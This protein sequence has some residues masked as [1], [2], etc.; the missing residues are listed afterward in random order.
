MLSFL[1]GLF[2][3]CSGTLMYEVVLTRLLSVISWY[4][5]A[6]V[7]ISMAMFGMTLGALFVQFRPEQFT[8]ALVPR[9]L[10]QASS[11]MAISIPLVLLTVLAFPVG[12]SP[13]IETLYSFVL[14]LAIV[15]VPFFFSG[16]VVCLSLTRA[17]FAIGIVYFADL[18]GASVGCFGS[19]V[20]LKLFDAPSAMFA[21][22]AILFVGTALYYRYA[23]ELRHRTRPMSAALLMLILAVL[24]TSTLHGIQPIWSKGKIDSRD[25]VLAEVWNPISRVRVSKPSDYPSSPWMWGASPHAP[26]VT[27]E[28]L[29]LDIDND[30]GTPMMHFRDDFND[31]DFLRYDVTS[32]A[33][34]LRVGGTAAIL[35][36]GGGRDAI[37]ALT[38]H[39]HRVVGI[40]VNCA[41][42]DITTRRFDWFSGFSKMPRLEVHCDEGRSY[43]SRSQERFDVVQ[44]SLVDTWAATSAG[45]MTLSENSLYTVEGWQ[46]FYRCLTPQGLLSFTRF[47]SGAERSQTYRL[48]S[49]AWATLLSEG[50]KNPGENIALI[51]SGSVATLLLSPQPLSPLDLQK[52]RSIAQDMAFSV[53]Y[54]PGEPVNIPELQKITATR[55]LRELSSLRYTDSLDFSPVY[56]SS[57]FFFHSVH[58]GRLPQ[59]LRQGFRSGGVRALLFL[60]GYGIAA[61]ILLGLAV[62][63]PLTRLGLGNGA[64]ATLLG[65]VTYFI[66]IGLAFMLVEIAMM[67]R[68]SIF[69]GHPIYSLVVVLAGLL[70]STGLGS[71]ASQRL[72]FASALTVR[73]PAFLACAAIL[74]YAAVSPSII[75]ES[76][77][78]MLWQRML[79]ALFLVMPCGFAMGF[80]F[81]AGLRWMKALG[82]QRNLPWMWSL[83]G[84]ASVLGSFVA[85]LISMEA[86]IGAC[87]LT[88]AAGYALAAVVLPYRVR[89]V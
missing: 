23:K 62:V 7:S 15:S 56:D 46:V 40:D 66:G 33:V 37:A 59:L 75:H 4:Y 67:Q 65:G 82:Q 16:I 60:F 24:N 85:V 54:L 41:I 83:N 29:N 74:G 52:L 39:F 87:L 58:L 22:S 21:I 80:C 50:V 19:V 72:A 38:N 42:V 14:F 86:S 36:I 25:G 44:A 89:E 64:H 18:L 53:L 27:I 6:F 73:I 51:G 20:L 35:G 48:F 68:L 71:L 10:A 88:A 32:L 1:S 45:A 55:S 34:Q 17:P 31:F 8:E 70:L 81:P 57:P 84:A 63:L 61:A 79:L 49:L 76:T 47:F 3:V 26:Q 69:L 5:L 30:A 9:R 78:G 11:A 77:T 28:T 13:S 43:L 2:L 12:F